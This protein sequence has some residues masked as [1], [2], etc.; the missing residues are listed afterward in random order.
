VAAVPARREPRA[1][2]EADP[3]TSFRWNRW[4]RQHMEKRLARRLKNPMSN[5]PRL[6]RVANTVTFSS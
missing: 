6:E 5:I 3:P 1:E 4:W 2:R